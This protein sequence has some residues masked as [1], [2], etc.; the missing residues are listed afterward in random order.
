M[1]ST[2]LLATVM[3]NEGA[4][5]WFRAA[6]PVWDGDQATVE[7]SAEHFWREVVVSWNGM[8][9]TDGSRL[10]IDAEAWIDGEWRGP[11]RMGVWTA[12]DEDGR[13]SV[14]EQNDEFA[15]VDTDVLVAKLPAQGLRLHLSV[16]G[17]EHRPDWVGVS[18]SPEGVEPSGIVTDLSPVTPL[19]VPTRRQGDYPEPS[20]ICSPTS[21]TMVLNF[22]ADQASREDLRLAVP[23]VCAGVHDPGW[24]GYGNWS[25]NAAFAGSLPGMR[26]LVTR[27]SGASDLQSWVAAGVPVVTSVCF[28]RLHDRG[29][30][31]SGHLVVVRGVDANGDIIVTDGGRNPYE[32]TIPQTRFLHAWDHSGRTVYLVYPQDHPVPEL[33]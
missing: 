17:G 8:P 32:F 30:T 4:Q 27:L 29:T 25:F 3:M 9:L 26:A 16:I 5:P 21:L 19:P 24:P 1:I 11:Y 23:E 6:E 2:F 10:E 12:R 13:G 7:F 18:F 22:W 14:N 33:R 15:R 31:S 28:N 20:R